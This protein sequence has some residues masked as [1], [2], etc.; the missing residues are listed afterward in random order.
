MRDMTSFKNVLIKSISA[1]RFTRE[2]YEEVIAT[3]AL[4]EWLTT[5]EV[6][7]CLAVLDKVYPVTEEK[8]EQSTEQ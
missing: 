4:N 6:A 1:K 2:Y 3:W 7:E 5:N 8:T